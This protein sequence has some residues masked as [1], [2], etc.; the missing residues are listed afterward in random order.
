MLAFVACDGFEI[1]AIESVD[2]TPNQRVE[3]SN[4]SSELTV[5][6]QQPPVDLPP[7]AD[8]GEDTTVDLRPGEVTLDASASHDAGGEPLQFRWRQVEGGSVSISHADSTS[9][10]ASFRK[11]PI[12]AVLRF[13]VEVSDPSGNSDTDSV[14]ITLE[15]ASPTAYAGPD[16]TVDPGDQFVLN[17][18]GSID[19]DSP[20]LSYSWTQLNGEIVELEESFAVGIMTGVAPE[21]P[22]SITF[23]LTV[24]DGFLTSTDTVEIKVPHQPVIASNFESAPPGSEVLFSAKDDAFGEGVRTDVRMIGPNRYLVLDAVCFPNGYAAV[25]FRLL[26]VEGAASDFGDGARLDVLWR[27]D[28]GVVKRE[29]LSVEFLGDT[30]TVYFKG[31]DRGFQSDWPN[32]LNGGELAV[33]IEYR[34]VREELF[35]L[36]L[37][38]QTPVQQ[39]LLSCGEY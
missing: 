6:D 38:G 22:Q 13:E 28:D 21:G 37:F 5:K 33:R 4:L 8:A 27:L 24:D 39:N 32:V 14:E 1:G 19:L 36:N 31:N 23:E 7:T 29:E 16:Q 18:T 12:E 2:K 26:G 25:G 35:D 15:R 34:G 10:I 11:L 30:P 9:P 3:S 20:E 17:G